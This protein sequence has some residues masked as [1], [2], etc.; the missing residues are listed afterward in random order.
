MS[1]ACSVQASGRRTESGSNRNLS[2]GSSSTRVNGDRESLRLDELAPLLS[3]MALNNVDPE[4]RA[5]AEVREQ[6]KARTE[7][8]FDQRKTSALSPGEV[9]LSHEPLRMYLRQMGSV[10]LLSRDGEVEL[11][12]RI[13]GGEFEA[14]IAVLTSSMS[15]KAALCLSCIGGAKRDDIDPEEL[16]ES[17]EKRLDGLCKQM[18]ALAR[19]QSKLRKALDKLSSTGTASAQKKLA[20]LDEVYEEIYTALE[21]MSLNRPQFERVCD[22]VKE[23]AIEAR[24]QTQ[25]I[26]HC[27]K[28]AR[29]SPDELLDTLQRVTKANAAGKKGGKNK[30]TIAHEYLE[31]ADVISTA[32][33]A[34]AD[35]SARVGMPVKELLDVD[36]RLR[37][38]DHTAAGARMEL[39]QANL[40]L[41][42]SIARKYTN[43]GLPFLDLIQEGN[44]GLMRAVEKFEYRRGYKFS[45][46]A[47]WWIRQAI[48][49]AIADQS[50]TIRVPVHMIDSINKLMRTNRRMVQELG[51]E[52]T[53]E[54]IAEELELPVDKV[55]TYLRVCGQPIS[56]ETPI[57]EDGD[58]FLGDLV[59]DRRAVNPADAVISLNLAQHTRD[60]LSTLAPRE[61]RVLRL[62]FGIGGEAP[63]TLEEV[64]RE[65]NVTRE[66]VRQIEAKALG[67]LRRPHIAGRLDSFIEA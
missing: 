67:K 42:V 46:Y 38:A 48:T 34:L 20:R 39:V 37:R 1:G 56:L 58:A 31:L 49:R 33:R 23:A 16:E 26:E 52:P 21:E 28:A 54:E 27:A 17:E 14:R 32:C 40:R 22:Q 47:H 3:T 63:R 5:A 59:E 66:R 19:E 2:V 35:V 11:S 50:R 61:E 30:Q 62:R 65:F 4:E 41:V 10:S 43:R 60:A 36:S 15:I 12:R 18:S 53:D 55:R 44:I 8:L 25:R 29:M 9:G 7:K 51:R 24:E 45:T 6:L 57:G 13:E 64:G